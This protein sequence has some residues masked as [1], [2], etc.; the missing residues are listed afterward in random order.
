[1]R[2]CFRLLAF[3]ALI[4]TPSLVQAAP[5]TCPE[6][7]GPTDRVFTVDT[8][9]S[10]SC[11]DFGTGAN[12]INGNPS[13]VIIGDP[14]TDWELVDKDNAGGSDDANPDMEDWLQVVGL[15]GLTGTFTIDADAW[16]EYDRLL[17]GF[18][19]G[20]GQNPCCPDWAVF[21]LAS[22]VLTG[23]WSIVP[24]EGSSLSHALLYGM[25][26]GEIITEVPEPASLLL[27]GG[28]LLAAL[29]RRRNKR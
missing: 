16:A 22:D 1:M 4:A 3:I 23:G 12:D 10:S 28:G 15:G 8:T 21:E 19:V 11:Y 9:P 27:V 20:G 14:S 7:P 24:P 26:D 17:I 2:T 5:V 6:I 25:D 13:D 18:K 29:R